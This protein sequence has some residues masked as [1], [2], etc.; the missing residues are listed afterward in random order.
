MPIRCSYT[1]A[2]GGAGGKGYSWRGRGSGWVQNVLFACMEF[3]KKNDV[4]SV[5][6]IEEDVPTSASGLNIRIHLYPMYT[7]EHEYTLNKHMDTQRRSSV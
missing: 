2:V 6:V 3:W 7:H 1:H 5:E 4:E